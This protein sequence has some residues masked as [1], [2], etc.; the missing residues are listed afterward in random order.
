MFGYVAAPSCLPKW[1]SLNDV[2]K[3]RPAIRSNCLSARTLIPWPA[4][5][6]GFVVCRL[7]FISLRCVWKHWVTCRSDGTLLYFDSILGEQGGSGFIVQTQ[8]KDR[9][10]TPHIRPNR[11]CLSKWVCNV[12]F[13]L[14][15]KYEASVSSH[16]KWLWTTFVVHRA[17]D[18]CSPDVGLS[19]G[20][21][22]KAHHA[23]AVFLCAVQITLSRVIK[24]RGVASV[25]RE[26]MGRWP[27]LLL[28]H[29]VTI[30][31]V[32]QMCMFLVSSLLYTLFPMLTFL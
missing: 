24:L 23:H 6:R 20:I 19:V 5:H 2:A 7:L 25:D 31:D 32:S 1:R 14:T 22:I 26:C 10:T 13:N 11:R 28:R 27:S 16:I 15:S 12:F 17:T 3:V 8:Q 21:L 18:V 9:S 30:T 4:V 29:P